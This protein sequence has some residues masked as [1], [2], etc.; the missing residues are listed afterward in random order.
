MHA[1]TNDRGI[2]TKDQGA[3]TNDR[4]IETEDQGA[5]RDQ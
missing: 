5:C 2:E 3:E 4:G 1:E